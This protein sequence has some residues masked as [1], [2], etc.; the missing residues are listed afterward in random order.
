MRSAVVRCTTCRGASQVEA[1]AL[2]LTV[3]CPRCDASFIAVEEI[4]THPLP[5]RA[6]RNPTLPVPEP[7]PERS[8]R[9]RERVGERDRDH[10]RRR[11]PDHS[12]DHHDHDP[13]REPPGTLPASVLIGLA[14]L[15]FAIPIFWLIAPAVVGK[16]PAMSIATPSA[17]AVSASVLCLAV[18]YTVDWTATTRVK[19]VL[20]LVCLAYFSALSLY[21]VKKEMVDKA[22]RFVGAEDRV[23][24]QQLRTADYEVSMPGPPQPI[25][26]GDSPIQSVK[27]DCRTADCGKVIL[28]QYLFVVGSG[29]S[30]DN[31]SDPKP[32]SDEWFKQIV[33]EIVH[34][35]GGQLHN[36]AHSI[37]Y[38]QFFPGRELEI[39]FPGEAPIRI[40][41][42][43]LIRGHIYYLSAQGIGMNLNDDYARIFFRSFR[44]PRTED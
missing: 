5:G 16:A 8:R 4:D 36:E 44:V 29:R 26:E 30:P 19:G 35:S 39:V 2:G 42:V 6:P 12:P 43:Y 25:A 20:M 22:R 33:D 31:A 18:I 13:H 3:R 21:F 11:E 38:N 28:G 37:Q 41:R 17:L 27:L 40:V 15:P 23:H 9:R 32:G 14:L 1:E 34:R 10:R 24:W 7:R